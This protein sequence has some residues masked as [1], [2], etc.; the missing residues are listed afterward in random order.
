ML[1]AAD[2]QLLTVRL[3]GETTLTS[4][5]RD[6]EIEI[7]QSQAGMHENQVKNPQHPEMKEQAERFFKGC[8]G[9]LEELKSQSGPVLTAKKK[10]DCSRRG[11]QYRIFSQRD[12]EIAR[13]RARSM[14]LDELWITD[15]RGN[16]FVIH[17]EYNTITHSGYFPQW[18]SFLPSTLGRGLS[19]KIE[20]GDTVEKIE[21]AHWT[22]RIDRS[23]GAPKF[24][25][26]LCPEMGNLWSDIEFYNKDGN[27]KSRYT[28][29]R[30][31]K[32]YKDI[33][34]PYYVKIEYLHAD[35][36][37]RA[38]REVTVET[39]AWNPEFPGDHFSI[40][41]YLDKKPSKE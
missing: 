12:P 7:T 2:A 36:T 17:P 11:R 32:I 35:G 33:R 38:I 20:D 15:K 9:Y 28:A 41:E 10:V 18:G 27:P 29:R 25:V 5:D 16:A 8:Q 34:I 31:D 37:A 3:T 40:D 19:A 14:V 39:A 1:K 24:S 13:A 30:F 21:D 22:H 23:D 6:F 26:R 4:M